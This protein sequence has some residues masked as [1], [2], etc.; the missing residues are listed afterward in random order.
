MRAM[1]R[2][3]ILAMAL[4]LVGC[5]PRGKALAWEL[6]AVHPHQVDCYTQGLEFH[7]GI[8]LE[9]GG[10]YGESKLR[11]VDPTTGAVLQERRLPAQIFSEG[12]TLVGTELWLLTWQAGKAYVFDRES[13]ELKRTHRYRG[14][15]WGLAFDGKQLIMSD[16]SN[17]LT[18]RDPETFDVLGTIEVMRDGKPQDQLNELEWVDGVIYANVYQQDIIVRIDAKRGAVTGVLELS[19]LRRKLTDEK[20][21]AEELNG[22]ARHPETGHFWVTGKYW[23]EIFEIRIPSS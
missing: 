17:Q 21:I 13:F 6:V 4:L 22:I 14:E 2:L 15:G 1:H 16:G 5:K 3:L 8:L 7:D 10:Q 9:S 18:L 11:R 23:S 12:L 20:E 19:G